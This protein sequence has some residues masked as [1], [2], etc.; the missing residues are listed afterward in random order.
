MTAEIHKD[1]GTASG[2]AK[3]GGKTLLLFGHTTNLTTDSDISNLRAGGNMNR[4]IIAYPISLFPPSPM[5]AE[6]NSSY[7]IYGECVV[8]KLNGA[9]FGSII[10]SVNASPAINSYIV[11]Q[12]TAGTYTATVTLTAIAK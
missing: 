7:G 5:T 9:T 11:G 6:Y 4:N 10:Q 8:V 1:G 2:Y 3:V 12:D